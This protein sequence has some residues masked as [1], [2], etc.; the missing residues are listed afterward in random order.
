M[1]ER[2][3][4]PAASTDPSRPVGAPSAPFAIT[5]VIPAYQAEST[6]QATLASLRAQT[7]LHWEAVVVD[8]GSTDA[9]SAVVERIASDD[10][11]VRLVRQMHTGPGAA[12]N[13][14]V[15]D[16]THPWLLFLDA[17]DTVGPTLL[18][19]VRD[20]LDADAALDAVLFGWAIVTDARATLVEER[21]DATGDLFDLLARERA[22]ANNACVVRRTLVDAAGGFHL[23][24]SAA[25]EWVVWQRIARSGARFR[26]L[27]ETLV[28]SPAR[29]EWVS[30]DLEARLDGALATIALGHTVDPA[31]ALAANAPYTLGRLGR[32]DEA[33]LNALCWTAGALIALG[34]DPVVLLDRITPRRFLIDVDGVAT[35]IVRAAPLVLA[36]PRE[37]WADLWPKLRAPLERFL[38]A[39]ESRIDRPGIARAVASRMQR[40]I[41]AYLA[42]P[43][44]HA[45]AGTRLVVIELTEPIG[46]IDVESTVEQVQLLVQLEGA[47]L[48]VIE[49]PC[50]DD[51]V[52]ALAVRNAVSDQFAWTVM[53]RFLDRDQR[54][55]VRASHAT[56]DDRSSARLDADGWQRFVDE[57]CAPDPPLYAAVADAI[58]RV[59]ARITGRD[60][61]RKRGVPRTLIVEL[62]TPTPRF[63]FGTRNVAADLLVAGV[64]LASV[65]LVARAGVLSGRALRAALIRAA[66]FELCRIVVRD[67]LLGLPFHGAGSL[68]DRVARMHGRA[69]SDTDLDRPVRAPIRVLSIDLSAPI[70]PIDASSGTRGVRLLLRDHGEPVGWVSVFNRGGGMDAEQLT[71]AIFAQAG[72]SVRQHWLLGQLTPAATSAGTAPTPVSVVVCTRDRTESL[73]RCLSALRALD[74]PHFEVLV[75]D[76]APSTSDTRELVHVMAPTFPPQITLRYVLEHRPGLDW[77]R[78]AGI[79]H[80]EHAFVAFTDDDVRV[81]AGWLTALARAFADP[82]VMVVTGLV[83]PAELDS[84]AQLL[85]E[86]A[87]GGMG[88]GM[89]PRRW[90]RDSLTIDELLGAHHVGVGANMAF[91]RALFDQVGDFDTALDV[92]TPAHGGGDLEMFHRVLCAG[93]VVHYQPAALVW[94]SH[95]S[96]RRGLRRQ[97]RDNGRAFGVYLMSCASRRTVPRW[98]VLRYAAR[99]WLPWLL[100][101]LGRSLLG[102]DALPASQRAAELVG[103]LQSPWAFIRSR[104][105]DRRLRREVRDD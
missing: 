41:L 52:T 21:C 5:I 79:E 103:V 87:Y 35:A 75:V 44:P 30:S 99:T 39:L 31:V 83:A 90:Q 56:G 95:R 101:R 24:S 26:H 62:C 60:D 18:R 3:A 45:V 53:T 9:T 47:T 51:R 54:A 1:T 105:S 61:G 88:K 77:A 91:R 11:R 2:P 65:E 32:P 17:G 8:D 84:D 25:E 12:R 98:A 46:D 73:R 57:L 85:F 50:I 29:D 68:R 76:N 6:I 89:R 81:D 92:G 27:A 19:L 14:G 23:D 49:L 80:A 59:S 40:C 64:P 78:N 72:V 104:S 93:V 86:D 4:P 37:D 97:L 71:A 58:D 28:F 102:Q 94:H 55:I 33:V 22:F 42:P 7:W 15:R 48:G 63:V 20:A 38:T 16:A 74:Y 69:W 96:D 70:A 100:G 36:R 10:R 43:L 13:A 67:T 34:R 82:D 66:G